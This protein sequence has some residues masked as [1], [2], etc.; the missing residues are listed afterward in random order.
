[1]GR[2][3]PH[4]HQRPPWG[5]EKAL[6]GKVDLDTQLLLGEASDSLLGDCLLLHGCGK[7]GSYAVVFAWF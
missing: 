2:E 7:G 6:V 3:T 4:A 5:E 1:M